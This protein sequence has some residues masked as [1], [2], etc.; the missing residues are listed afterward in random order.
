MDY[1]KITE[2]DV[3]RSEDLR[4]KQENEKIERIKKEESKNNGNMTINGEN[5]VE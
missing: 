1:L 2:D 5:L 4:I 3:Q